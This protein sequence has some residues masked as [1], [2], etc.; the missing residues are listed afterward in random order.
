MEVN[1]DRNQGVPFCWSGRREKAVMDQ[2]V[3]NS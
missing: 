2:G 3:H 1:P